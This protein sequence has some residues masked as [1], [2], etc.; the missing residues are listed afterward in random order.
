MTIN[1]SALTYTGTDVGIE[2]WLEGFDNGPTLYNRSEQHSVEYTNLSAGTYIFHYRTLNSDGVYS[3]EQTITFVKTPRFQETLWFPFLVMI[4]TI[5]IVFVIFF[6]IAKTRINRIKKK[7]E[8]YK[9]ITDE[10]IATISGAIDA[11]D[12]YTEGHSK[13]VADFSVKIGKKYGLNADDCERLYYIALLH[14]IGKIGVPDDILK[15]P[16]RLTDEE[17]QTIKQHTVAGGEILKNF[18]ILKGVDEGAKYHHERYDLQG[19]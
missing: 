11:K 18:T 5:V 19:T 4:E 1:L 6:V 16:S 12:P 17:F 8:E 3:E 7:E 14:D 15:K 10:T 9:Q 13:R 2:Y